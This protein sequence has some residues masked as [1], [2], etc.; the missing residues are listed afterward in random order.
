MNII[1]CRK[2]LNLIFKKLRKTT[3]DQQTPQ[4]SGVVGLLIFTFYFSIKLESNCSILTNIS[5]VSL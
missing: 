2:F 5:S 3:L 1:Q 4:I